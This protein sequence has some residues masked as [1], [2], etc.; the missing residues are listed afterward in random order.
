MGGATTVASVRRHG[1]FQHR[2]APK[3]FSESI[4]K[5]MAVKSMDLDCR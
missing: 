2:G 5:R 4:A 1:M 3:K